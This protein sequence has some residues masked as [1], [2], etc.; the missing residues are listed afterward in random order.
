MLG[1]ASK[2]IVDRVSA[3]TIFV[4]EDDPAMSGTLS[5]ALEATGYRV[6]VASTGGEA[7]AL[8]DE[9]QPDLIIL[10]LMLPDDDG[11]SLTTSLRALTSAPIVICSARQGQ[12]DRVLG[13]KLGAADF[14]TKPFELDDLEARVKTLLCRSPQ[15]DEQ[16]PRDEIQP[17]RHGRHAKLACVAVGGRP[18][19]LILIERAALARIEGGSSPA[20]VHL[21]ELHGA[22]LSSD[23]HSGVSQCRGAENGMDRK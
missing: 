17:R 14:V 16:A 19:H 8:F 11:L 18:P 20:R 6:L 4:V 21:K 2:P 23:D 10:D 5:K 22:P 7:R 13:L 1:C 9:A 3:A 12:I 15:P